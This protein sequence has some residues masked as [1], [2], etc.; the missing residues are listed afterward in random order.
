M[1]VDVDELA[2]GLGPALGA[3]Q[4]EDQQMADM[5]QH[6]VVRPRRVRREQGTV[7]RLGDDLALVEALHQVHLG[8]VLEDREERH[9]REERPLRGAGGRRLG[10]GVRQLPRAVPLLAP[11]VQ[12]REVG[13][14][15]RRVPVQDLQPELLELL[16]GVRQP[17]RHRQLDDVRDRVTGGQQCRVAARRSGLLHDDPEVVRAR[18]RRPPRLLHQELRVHRRATRVLGRLGAPHPQPLPARRLAHPAGPLRQLQ[19][20]RTREGLHPLP[21][22]LADRLRTGQQLLRRPVVLGTL[23]HVQHVQQIL[24]GPR[25]PHVEQLLP[26]EPV[27]RRVRRVR[28]PRLHLLNAGPPTRHDRPHHEPD[29]EHRHQ[30][31]ENLHATRVPDAADNC[32]TRPSTCG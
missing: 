1:A 30:D 28:V 24:V 4:E 14:H 11:V 10:E 17:A 27:V 7:D 19:C 16:T 20:R 22:D 15:V 31:P 12:G 26:H 29:H 3:D 23:H 2:H 6:G 5:G 25:H 8:Q 32:P 18:C 21:P 13:A 9:G